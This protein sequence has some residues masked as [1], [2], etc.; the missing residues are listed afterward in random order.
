MCTDC[1]F[2]LAMPLQMA[3]DLLSTMAPEDETEEDGETPV[4]E[5]FDNLLHS[6]KKKKWVV[7]D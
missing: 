2:V 4:Y 6:S 3:A 7:N 1:L 5:R